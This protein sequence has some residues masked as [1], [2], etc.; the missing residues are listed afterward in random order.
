MANVLTG[1][2]LFVESVTG[3]AVTGYRL[4]TK[5]VW[6]SDDGTNMDIATD[7]DFKMTDTAGNV[8]LG[9]QA[10]GA[11]DGD[12]WDYNPPFRVNGITVTELDGGVL[13]I[14]QR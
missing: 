11:G 10:K 14:Y 5:V 9:K 2:P 12:T 4:I 3:A 8:L 13:Y 1:N 6:S 7:D